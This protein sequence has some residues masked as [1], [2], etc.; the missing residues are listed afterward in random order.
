MPKAWLGINSL[1][2]DDD[3]QTC[4]NVTDLL[5]DMGLRAQFVTDG[6]SAVEKVIE[7]KDT[8]DPS[9]W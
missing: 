6:A 2:V 4:E 5:K 7:E 9:S 3:R 8:Q 1:I